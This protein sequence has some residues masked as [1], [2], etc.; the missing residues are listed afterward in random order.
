MARPKELFVV[1][2]DG[3]DEQFY[4]QYLSLLEAA[5]EEGPEAEIF[6]AS[7]ESVGSYDLVTKLVRPKKAAK[8]KK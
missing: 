7:L 2:Q 3:E 5:K 8:R 1:W 4:N 6:K